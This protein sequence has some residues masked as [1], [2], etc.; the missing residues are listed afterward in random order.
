MQGLVGLPGV[1]CAPCNCGAPVMNFFLLLLQLREMKEAEL[2]TNCL[3]SLKAAYIRL[4]D[5]DR[6]EDCVQLIQ[7]YF[8]DNDVQSIAEQLEIE[9]ERVT[10][11]GDLSAEATVLVQL[12]DALVQSEHVALEHLRRALDIRERL[13]DR[14]GSCECNMKIGKIKAGQADFKSALESF[15]AA[16]KYYDGGWRDG[17]EKSVQ[18]AADCFNSLGECCLQVGENKEAILALKRCLALR[19]EIEDEAGCREVKSQ[20]GVT[21]QRLGDTRS[22]MSSLL[23]GKVDSG[24]GGGLDEPGPGK[25]VGLSSVASTMMNLRRREECQRNIAKL[26]STLSL[27]KTRGDVASEANCQF[28]LGQALSEIQQPLRAAESYSTC[29]QLRRELGDVEGETVALKR[30]GCC[31]M[32]A[33]NAKRAS[34]DL[35]Q[36]L[37]VVSQQADRTRFLDKNFED[38]RREEVDACCMLGRAYLVQGSIVNA[39]E[40]LKRALALTHESGDRSGEAK[41]LES[42]GGLY[43]DLWIGRRATEHYERA[44]AT[45]IELNDKAGEARCLMRLGMLNFDRGETAQCRKCMEEAL[46][47]CKQNIIGVGEADCLM[48]IGDVLWRLGDYPQTKA[49]YSLAAKLCRE[50]QDR[51][52]EAKAICGLSHVNL[53]LGECYQSIEQVM[54]ALTIYN[55]V[56]DSA[57]QASALRSLAKGYAT[58]GKLPTANKVA[59]Q[60]KAISIECGDVLAAAQADVILSEILLDGGEWDAAIRLLL[61]VKEVFSQTADLPGINVFL[62]P[63]ELGN[64]LCALGDAY[65]RAGQRDMALGAFQQA[66]IIFKA[67]EDAYGLT[68]Q[69]CMSALVFATHTANG[70]SCSSDEMHDALARLKESTDKRQAHGNRLGVAECILNQVFDCAPLYPPLPPLS[71]LFSCFPHNLPHGVVLQRLV[72]VSKLRPFNLRES[73]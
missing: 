14:K 66:G 23:H 67:S 10:A 13:V 6:A 62:S 32:D 2:A 34:E 56:S 24:S 21:Y 61:E 11:E 5:N 25:V 65:R 16:S 54:E 20:L 26:Q 38:A 1:A 39:C 45:Y 36:Y 68:K 70:Q 9:L 72:C 59:E 52:G 3:H 29:V 37:G 28:A 17:T 12:G 71:T 69:L 51:V 53:A 46:A 30:Q 55:E 41:C 50:Q 63:R 40:A 8:P 48:E 73:C 27:Y 42:F 4:G 15:R 35:E 64:T 31:Y 7:E 57:G 49:H 58:Q 43:Q 60:A 47:L 44:F 18:A 19:E 33:G 22:A